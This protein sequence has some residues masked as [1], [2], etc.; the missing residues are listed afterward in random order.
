MGAYAAV[1]E[2][3]KYAFALLKFLF[4]VSYVADMDFRKLLKYV[5]IYGQVK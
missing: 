1:Y 4:S 2:I 3:I 5:L